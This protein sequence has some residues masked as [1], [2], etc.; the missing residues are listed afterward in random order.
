MDDSVRIKNGSM[1]VDE[2]QN[3]LTSPNNEATAS[4]DFVQRFRERLKDNIL[5]E[6]VSL[7]SLVRDLH[8]HTE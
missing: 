8:I 3:R 4:K 1:T 5:A 6:T 7:H 2:S